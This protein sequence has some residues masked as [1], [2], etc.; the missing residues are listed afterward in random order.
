MI[1]TIKK[2]L[3]FLLYCIGGIM[4]FSQ[5]LY[6]H[7]DKKKIGLGEPAV[8]K[9]TIENLQGKPV[10][11]PAKNELLPFHFEVIK[12][13]I[14]Q[15]L[16]LYV[17]TIEF[18][19]FEEGTF[20]IPQ[21][22]IKVGDKVESTVPYSIE[23]VNPAQKEDQINDIMNNKEVQLNVQDYWEQYKWY[24]LGIIGLIAAIIAAIWLIKYAK[25]KK[26]SP[27][28]TTNITLKK[29]EALKKKQY[30]EN[31]DYRSFYVELLD[32]SRGFLTTQ[33]HIP[34]NVL[35]TDDLIEYMKSNNVISQENE[36]IIEEVFSR[37]DM[38]KFAKIFPDTA[39][40]EKDFEGIKKVVKNSIKDLEFENLRKDV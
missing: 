29:L 15:E 27:A 36:T 17:R 2:A 20:G 23:V 24:I 11:I 37:G 18:T 10:M 28:T 13:S 32:I 8:Y 1:V 40:M 12:D 7:L 35:L 34:A 5:T 39:T 19:V 38:V 21:F 30:I 33:Y 31:G 16:D 3:S 25:N 6:S 14:N 26:S 22:D 4:V 9:I